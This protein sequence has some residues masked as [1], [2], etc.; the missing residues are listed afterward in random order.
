MSFQDELLP[1]SFAANVVG[2]H[3]ERGAAWLESLPYI[4]RDTANRFGLRLG[5]PFENI[6]YSYVVRAELS[7]STPVVL[8]LCVPNEEL[9]SEAE[10]LRIYDGE[11]MA[12][13]LGGNPEEG[14]LI[15]EMLEPATP[16]KTLRN[17]DEATEAA[18]SLMLELR[19]PALEGATL[20]NVSVWG[21]G[22]ARLRSEFG[23]T[24]GPFP[25]DMFDAA[26]RVFFELVESAE[27]QVVLHGDLH[28]LNVC[29]S[30]RRSWL[31]IDPKGVLG[32]PAYETGAFLRNPFTRVLND[33]NPV[34]LIERRVR[35]LSERLNVPASRIY[36]WGF[37]QAVLAACWSWEDEAGDWRVWTRIAE[38]I[39][40]SERL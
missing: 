37:A 34:R 17:D 2:V 30:S 16:L 26:E 35:I 33:A 14:A 36:G 3:G 4:L 38:I 40:A 13:L 9:S 22:F 15:I 11:G 7:D 29:A 18:A 1:K 27:S 19:R 31:A 21:R 28:H 5:R 20:P 10:T 6:S 8:K 23:G 12:K 39:R 32:D 24:S 25:S